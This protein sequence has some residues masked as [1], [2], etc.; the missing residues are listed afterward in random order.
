MSCGT[1]CVMQSCNVILLTHHLNQS[2][3]A[4]VFHPKGPLENT[5][6]SANVLAMRYEW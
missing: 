1:D 4:Y 5:Q 6:G 3:Y 2:T